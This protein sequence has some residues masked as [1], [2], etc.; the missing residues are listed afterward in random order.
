MALRKKT[1][2][3]P[4][5]NQAPDS[6]EPTSTGEGSGAQDEDPAQG[7]EG[8]GGKG[9]HGESKIPQYPATHDHHDA[10]SSNSTS[11]ASDSTC[12]E[13]PYVSG[14]RS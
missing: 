2:P 9:P 8:S 6:E 13:R 1:S 14:N 3:R 12:S 4:D 11:D 5:T 10:L 7:S